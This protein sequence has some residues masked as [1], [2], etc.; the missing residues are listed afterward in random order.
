MSRNNI[1]Q[2]LKSGE[3]IVQRALDTG[4]AQLNTEDFAL[5]GRT[6]RIDGKSVIN[7][8]S[9]SYLGLDQHPDLKRGTIE[10]T[11]RYGSQ[12]SSSRAYVS[13]GLYEELED[14]LGKMFG[15]SVIAT[16][17]TTLGHL[18]ALPS[19]INADDVL[20][21]DH[22]VHASVNMAVQLVKSTGV[23]VEMIR[24]NNMDMLESRIKKLQ[25]KYKRIWYFADGVYS[26]FGDFAPVSALSS[27][28]NQYEC[29][30][31][32]ID[33]A[34]GTSWA[35]KNGK[36][37][38]KTWLNGHPR[39][40]VAAS[41]NKSFAA[42]GGAL[43]LPNDEMKRYI[44]SSGGTLIF[45]GP[46]Q[47]PMLGAA[48]ASANLHLSRELS[49]HQGQLRQKIAN[50]RDFAA[51]NGVPIMKPNESPIFFIPVGTPD[52]GFDLVRRMLDRG[53]YLN[54]AAYPSVPLNQTGVRLTIHNHLQTEDLLR[55]TQALAEELPQVL[56]MHTE[57]D[58]QTSPLAQ[59]PMILKHN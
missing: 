17:S 46:I 45:G 11:K 47:P 1:A 52:P 58:A 13:L 14:L 20:I 38:A 50:F 8:S 22:Q 27:L 23:R 12:F 41:L 2:H 40:V 3:Q 24:H 48:I 16:A 39:V 9:C 4:I 36:G 53:F 15:G 7:F 33:D 57:K 37:F 10:A 25:S 29:L 18:S 51:R 59:I 26:M 44:R 31:L 54:I 34:H 30:H 19:L 43:I 55:L 35:G 32:Y 21:L 49:V 28:L 56:D 42:A 5:D 6:I